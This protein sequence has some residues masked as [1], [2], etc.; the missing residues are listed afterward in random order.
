MF[1][2][3]VNI[4]PF[5]ILWLTFCCTCNFLF[6]YYCIMALSAVNLLFIWLI[7]CLIFHCIVN[8]KQW[9]GLTH[10]IKLLGARQCCTRFATFALQLLREAWDQTHILTKLAG[11]LSYSHSK[12]KHAFPYQNLSLKTNG[13]GLKRTGGYEKKINNRNW[14]WLVYWTWDHLSNWWMVAIKNSS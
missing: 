9:M 7:V 11:N 5:V 1:S 6:C 2:F 12:I 4:Q 13:M 8:H 14:S 10:M 3:L